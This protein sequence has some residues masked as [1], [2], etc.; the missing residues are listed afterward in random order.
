MML[1]E[2]NRHRNIPA[3]G[4]DEVADVTGAGDTVMATF[5]LALTAGASYAD[6]AALANIAAGL[7]VMKAGTATVTVDELHRALTEETA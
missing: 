1:V 3:F 2:K 4:P 5:A 6:A 7:V